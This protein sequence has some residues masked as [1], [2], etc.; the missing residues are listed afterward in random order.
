MKPAW[1]RFWPC[2]SAL[3]ISVVNPCS[4]AKA[5]SPRHVRETKLAGL[6]PGVDTDELAKRKLRGYL[7]H[8]LSQDGK[9]I[10]WQRACPSMEIQVQ[11]DGR[12]VIQSIMVGVWHSPV[13]AQCEIVSS[14]K[15]A[16]RFLGT[17]QGL[18]FNQR[19]EGIEEIYGTAQSK[20]SSTIDGRQVESYT[21]TFESKPK[22]AA[23]K[24]EVSCDVSSNSI[25]KL[26]LAT[27]GTSAQ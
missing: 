8:W 10:T 11:A 12:G 24:L 22:S 17:G 9:T 4:T 25:T 6:R 21:Y 20:E 13:D 1:K 15:W 18:K 23:L 5:N 2:A 3:A 26:R 27:I 7:Y 14:Q 19:C 16:K